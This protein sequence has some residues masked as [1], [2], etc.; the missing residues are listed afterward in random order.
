MIAIWRRML[1]RI[2]DGIF[3]IGHGGAGRLSVGGSSIGM[4]REEKEA[5]SSVIVDA[6]GPSREWWAGFGTVTAAFDGF[7]FVGFDLKDEGG[8]CLFL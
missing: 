7:R 2:S 6:G 4:R 5:I 8:K 1:I 3:E